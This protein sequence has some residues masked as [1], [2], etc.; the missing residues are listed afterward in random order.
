M[1]R[2]QK[3]KKTSLNPFNHLQPIFRKPYRAPFYSLFVKAVLQKRTF[4][5]S[6]EK[7]DCTIERRRPLW[8][9]RIPATRRIPPARVSKPAFFPK[10]TLSRSP[11]KRGVSDAFH[12]LYL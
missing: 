10:I 12:P 11:E 9:A 2:S 3:F 7:Y 8:P 5:P 6:K 1:C 4:P